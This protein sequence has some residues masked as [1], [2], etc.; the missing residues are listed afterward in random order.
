[1]AQRCFE[2]GVLVRASGENIV[3]SPP[4]IINQEQVAQVF[5]T[6]GKALEATR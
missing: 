3:L 1:V 5:S 4:L 6:L 2:A